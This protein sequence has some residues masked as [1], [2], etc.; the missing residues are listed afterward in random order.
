MGAACRLPLALA[1]FVRVAAMPW[2]RLQSPSGRFLSFAEREEIG[3]LRAQR[4]GVR[5]IAG[6]LGRSPSMISR[7]VRRNAATRGGQLE[8]E[9]P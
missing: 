9:S 3:L 5:K 4:L 6:R 1:G 7:E 2:M 8:G